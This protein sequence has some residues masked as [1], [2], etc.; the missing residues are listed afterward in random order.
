MTKH[1]H[2]AHAPGAVVCVNGTGVNG[3]GIVRSLGRHRIPVRVLGV[4]GDQNLAATSRYSTEYV[5][6]ER[7]EGRLIYAALLRLH[8][9]HGKS[10]LYFDNDIM[11]IEL[12]TYA[13]ELE[14]TF[15][16]TSDLRRAPQL[17]NKAYQTEAAREAGLTVPRTWFPQSWR[18]VERIDTDHRL[19]VKPSPAAFSGGKPFKTLRADDIRELLPRLRARVTSPIGIV[20]QEYIEGPDS[21]VFVGLGYR[22]AHD[23]LVQMVTGIKLRQ[24]PPGAGVMTIGKLCDSPEVKDQTLRLASALDITGIFGVEYKYWAEDSRYYF[25]ELNARTELFHTLGRQ[26][27]LDLPR[28]AYRDLCGEDL[29]TV[30]IE[31]Q[32]PLY[33]IN[34]PSHVCSLR[35]SALGPV[36]S[37]VS[38]CLQRKQWAVFAPD[39]LR[40]WSKYMLSF[41]FRILRPAHSVA[42]RIAR[43][44]F[45]R[46]VPRSHLGL[47][48]SLDLSSP[49]DPYVAQDAI[50]VSPSSHVEVIASFYRRVS[51][52]LEPQSVREWLYGG[53][54]CWLARIEGHVVGGTWVWL[55]ACELPSLSGR[56]F[57]ARD[58][59]IFD[60]TTG[61]VCHQIVDEAFRC[62]GVGTRLLQRIIEHYRDEARL[63]KLV[64][65]MGA[66]NGASVR[67][68]MKCGARL[69]AIVR[70]WSIAGFVRR[71]EIFFDRKEQC[72][73]EPESP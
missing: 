57:A 21:H 4:S 54:Q 15:L 32:T 43:G 46:V 38:A 68:W 13:P 25:I 40:P 20:V 59:V 62:Q 28:L 23:G 41:L 73:S 8:A 36:G 19:L 58:G 52:N 27:G 3:L 18:D 30:E 26:A 39:D 44:L 70:V 10:I 6:I 12:A 17:L 42:V 66:S 33:W 65:T 50:Q 5:E 29:S 49:E 14:N 51:R 67:C 2:T 71:R 1:K 63:S 37:T 11:M 64:A 53:H 69:I 45:R 7:R 16:L 61:L 22:S 35:S 31:R 48:L 34:F 56:C 55:E 9:L 47:I 72:W 60:A 24:A